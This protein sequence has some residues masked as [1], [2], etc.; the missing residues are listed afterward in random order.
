MQKLMPTPLT[1]MIF[2]ERLEM[3][4]SKYIH[5][6]SGAIVTH[7]EGKFNPWWSKPLPESYPLPSVETIMNLNE[8]DQ[9]TLASPGQWVEAGPLH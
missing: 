7:F 2:K 5:E 1:R 4:K 9:G 3:V 6:A 8:M